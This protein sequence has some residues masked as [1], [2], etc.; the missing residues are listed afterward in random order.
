MVSRRVVAQP[1]SHHLD[2]VQTISGD[3]Q[4][5]LDRMGRMRGLTVVR[6]GASGAYRISAVPAADV[7]LGL[8]ADL[9][10]AAVEAI[11]VI[12][13]V[14]DYDPSGEAAI[15]VVE[16]NPVDGTLMTFLIQGLAMA[17]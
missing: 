12:D 4:R 15:L 2:L 5:E 13:D 6:L 10:I 14:L 16:S 3:I 1:H 17:R 9:G 11:P 8:L 7:R